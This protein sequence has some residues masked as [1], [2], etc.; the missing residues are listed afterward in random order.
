M[1]IP[2]SAPQAT[3]QAAPQATPQAERTKEILK[4][5]LVPR[6]RG[7]IQEF[8]DLKDREYFRSEILNPLLEQ[9]L[10]HPTIPDKLTSPKQKYC[11]V[12]Q[13]GKK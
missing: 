9:G 11:S 2:L 8:L 13:S 4:F 6:K 12:K 5:C 10:L 7:E 3:P 1:I